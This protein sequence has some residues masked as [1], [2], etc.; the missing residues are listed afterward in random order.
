VLPPLR[1]RAEDVPLLA[2]R[3]LAQLMAEHGRR[4]ALAPGAMAALTAAPWPGNVRQLRNVL[5]RLVVASPRDVIEAEDVEPLVE[6]G[7]AAAPPPPPAVEEPPAEPDERD[8]VA[9]ALVQA[10][11]VQ[12]KAARLLGLT[13]RQ[14]RYRVA[15]YGL[16]L[17][18]F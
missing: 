10:G 3:F 16:V 18:R 14:L 1:D 13:V 8:R 2:E 5:E 4:I 12:A 9:A 6:T 7:P 15:K 17:R 11:Y